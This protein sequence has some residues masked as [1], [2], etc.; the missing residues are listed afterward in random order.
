MNATS[1]INLSNILKIAILVTLS[2]LLILI[3]AL[4][5]LV[6]NKNNFTQKAKIVSIESMNQSQLLSNQM[7]SNQE[8]CSLLRINTYEDYGKYRDIQA[9]DKSDEYQVNWIDK[10][11]RLA[12]SEVSL[13]DYKIIEKGYS[14]NPVTLQTITPQ[15]IQNLNSADY[16]ITFNYPELRY[17]IDKIFIEYAP[18]NPYVIQLILAINKNDDK[19]ANFYGDNV[20]STIREKLFDIIKNISINNSMTSFTEIKNM[21]KRDEYERYNDSV[22]INRYFYFLK[23]NDIPNLTEKKLMQTEL[24]VLRY[25]IQSS[26]I[27]NPDIKDVVNYPW[28]FTSK[29]GNSESIK[30]LDKKIVEINILPD[31]QLDDFQHNIYNSLTEFKSDQIWLDS[32]PISKH[33]KDLKKVFL[34]LKNLHR[35]PILSIVYNAEKLKIGRKKYIEEYKTCLNNYSIKY[36]ASKYYDDYES[37][38]SLKLGEANEY[39]AIENDYKYNCKN[40]VYVQFNQMYK[41]Y[42]E[43]DLVTANL[44]N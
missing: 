36:T 21:Q 31:S 41:D 12:K 34:N 44:I 40:N 5:F 2:L 13:K 17:K 25:D 24:C 22:L 33:L 8:L 23:L 20:S 7:Y 26:K 43:N 42:A 18:D 37:Y 27:I 35:Y 30:F 38:E 1:K 19:I 11:L 9:Q 32:D 6:C 10:I 39:S 16:L 15:Q 4:G 28:S 14:F 29:L 3:G